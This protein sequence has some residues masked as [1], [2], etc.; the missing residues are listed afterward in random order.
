MQRRTGTRWCFPTPERWSSIRRS[1]F[2]LDS[3]KS[4]E[5]VAQIGSFGNLLVVSP[6][7][8]VHDLREPA[9]ER[10]VKISGAKAQ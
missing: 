2:A 5:P 10:M 3:L 8:P 6:A 9:D 1:T 7:L 4:F